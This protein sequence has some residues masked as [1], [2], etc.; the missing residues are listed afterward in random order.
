M[1]SVFEDLI[2]VSI[3]QAFMVM[4]LLLSFELGFQVL[5]YRAPVTFS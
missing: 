4:D 5:L 2:S 1:Y 3:T